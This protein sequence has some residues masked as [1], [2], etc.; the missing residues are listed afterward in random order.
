MTTKKLRHWV[1][2]P[3][4]IGS[5]I[6]FGGCASKQPPT[7]KMA[8]TEAFILNAQTKDARDYVELRQA[9]DKLEQAKTAVQQKDYELAERLADQSLMD[10]KLA[11]AKADA[12]SSRKAAVEM[13]KSIETL[14]REVERATR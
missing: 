12:A 9:Q 10:A 6:L 8:T 13:Q 1:G 7:E 5:F 14:Q 2:M 3:I 11:E 4:M